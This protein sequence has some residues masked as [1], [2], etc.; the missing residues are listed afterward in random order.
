MI[1]LDLSS[2]LKDEEKEKFN[3]LGYIVNVSKRMTSY[4]SFTF[5]Y[6][7]FFYGGHYIFESLYICAFGNVERHFWNKLQ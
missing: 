4:L 6:P 5:I 2:R 3:P 1:F 7:I